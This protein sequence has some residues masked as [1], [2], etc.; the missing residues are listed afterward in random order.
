MKP[1]PFQLE[2]PTPTDLARET[3]AKADRAELERR[4]A[5]REALAAYDRAQQPKPKGAPGRCK[6]CKHYGD[7]CTCHSLRETL[8]P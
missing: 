2:A 6:A 5:A 8:T 7:D 4:Q 1:A 3:R